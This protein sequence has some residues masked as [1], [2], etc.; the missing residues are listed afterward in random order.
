MIIALIVF[1]LDQVTKIFIRRSIPLWGGFQVCPSFSIVHFQNTGAVFGVFQNGNLILI[2]VTA[3]ILIL[4]A[5]LHKDLASQGSWARMGLALLWGGAFGNF[6]DRIFVGSVTD[7]LDVSV[8]NW[9]RPAFNV[10]DSAITVGVFFLL[11]QH[12]IPAD[13]RS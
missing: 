12:F 4:L 1:I 7:F 10:A 6:V 11:L 8:K 9:H 13:G 3:A 2:G 5:K